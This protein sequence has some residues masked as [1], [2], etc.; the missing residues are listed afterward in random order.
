MDMRKKLQGIMGLVEINMERA[1]KRR[2]KKLYDR[3]A[4]QRSLAAGEMVLALLPNPHH[5]LKLEWM[6]PYKIL[7]QVT[8]VDYEIEM[9]GHWKERRIYHINLLKK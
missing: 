2:Q 4:L 9:T 5:S 3:R 8:A 6:G 1:Q 7:K